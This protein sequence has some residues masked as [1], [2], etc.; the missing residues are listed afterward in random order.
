MAR[1]PRKQST[2][3]APRGTRKPA[4][5]TKARP[6]GRTSARKAAKV[7]RRTAAKA[8]KVTRKPVAKAAKVTRKPA[9]KAVARKAVARKAAVRKPAARKPATRKAVA[10]KPVA[11]KAVARKA[12]AR[13]AV[14]RKTAAPK[15]AARKATSA[16]KP[17]PRKTSIRKTALRERKPMAGVLTKPAA[18]RKA[19]KAPPS[20]SVFETARQAAKSV[21]EAVVRA[22]GRVVPGGK[23]EAAGSA[24]ETA[25]ASPSKRVRRPRRVEASRDEP[26][27][28]AP[29]SLDVDTRSLSAGV[30]VPLGAEFDEENIDRS[31]TAGDADV[32][33][34]QAASSGE[35]APGGDNPTP[36]QDVVDLIGKAL[37]VEYDDNQELKGGAELVER[38]RKRWE[39][40][41]A[42]AEDYKDRRKG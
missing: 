21:G 40:N 15:V 9:R 17:A 1:K 42:S 5:T 28:G 3:A 35:E 25:K 18:P 22:V 20:T 8:A 32:D 19:P 16:R 6:A 7:T 27:I 24:P 12:V 36:D 29:S 10:R 39:L 26:L 14:A 38:D 34:Q 4:T 41:P 37:G 31:V 13:K 2:S 33:A 11:R 30:G 23:E